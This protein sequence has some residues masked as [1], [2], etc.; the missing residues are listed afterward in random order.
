MYNFVIMIDTKPIYDFLVNLKVPCDSYEEY[1]DILTKSEVN[2]RA[3]FIQCLMEKD[4]KGANV[5]LDD[6]KEMY[7]FLLDEKSSG[8]L[9]YREHTL[10]ALEKAKSSLK[11]A[12]NAILSYTGD[13]SLPEPK[14]DSSFIAPQPNTQTGRGKVLSGTEGLANFLGC[15]KSKAF[16]IIKSGVLKSEKIQY[17]V[18]NCWKFN[19]EKLENLISS[20][21]EIF[22]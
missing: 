17:K 4:G 22:G 16:K 20:Q 11:Y 14:V 3:A 1:Q 15:S 18:G 8:R 12:E 7:K 5:I 21:P 9:K 6:F 2:F 19:A 13:G 10:Y